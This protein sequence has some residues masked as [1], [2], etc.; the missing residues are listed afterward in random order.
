[1]GEEKALPHRAVG[2]AQLPREVPQG[3]LGYHSRT[4]SLSFCG[5]VW[6]PSIS[7]YYVILRFCELDGKDSGAKNNTV[8]VLLSARHCAYRR[9]VHIHQCSQ[10]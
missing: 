7:G 6:V 4:L 2:M 1:M 8:S 9:I 3:A 10:C 5:V